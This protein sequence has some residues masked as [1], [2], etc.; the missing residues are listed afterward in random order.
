[1]QPFEYAAPKTVPDAVA[2]LAAHPGARV[3]A[4]GTDLLVQLRAGRRQAGLLVDVKRIPQVNVLSFDAVDGLT[5][6]AAVPCALVHEHPE[7]RR[8]YPALA[9]TA[10]IIGGTLIQ[11]RA[12]I[13]GN[14]CNASPSADTVP[15][16]IALGAT[17]RL[18]GPAGARAVPVEE[19]CAGPGRSVLEAGEIL[20][21]L[22]VP[23]PAPGSGAAYLRFTPRS[24]M[25]IAVVGVGAAVSV[26]D[27]RFRSARI[28]LAAVAPV[29]LFVPAAGAALVGQ[30]VGEEAIARAAEAAAAASHP[31]DDMRGSAQYRRHLVGVLTRRALQAAVRRA[32]GR[33]D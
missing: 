31:I 22:T 18:A 23:P 6:G 19:F 29:P 13:G 15:L 5:I 27:G 33:A 26:D 32:E 9:E 12:T 3:L 11:N 16:L 10:G 28:A 21:A 4:G 1:M 17:C 14:L 20:V 24:E 30:P 25:D 7:V 8:H 2:L